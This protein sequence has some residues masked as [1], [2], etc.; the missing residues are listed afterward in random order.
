LIGH[1]FVRD[2]RT[3]VLAAVVLAVCTA[4]AFAVVRND[5]PVSPSPKPTTTVTLTDGGLIGRYEVT[6]TDPSG[7]AQQATF[8][9]GAPNNATGYLAQSLGYEACRTAIAFQRHY[10]ETGELPPLDCNAN[11]QIDHAGWRY[12]I[13]GESLTD[14]QQRYVPVHQEL[15][16]KTACDEA[17]WQE[18]KTLLPSS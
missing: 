6:A 2:R 8:R 11:G 7:T 14:G 13:T 16:V 10:L 9:C 17:L 5:G 15:T 12:V 4:A 18:M 3:L 1:H